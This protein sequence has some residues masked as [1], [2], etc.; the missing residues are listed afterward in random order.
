MSLATA[1][2]LVQTAN[3]I[4]ILSGAGL[5]TA[6]GIPDFRG[7]QGLWTADPEAEKISTLHYY[8][9]DDR[10]RR[11]AWQYRAGSPIWEAK[12]NA[13][14]LALVS[15]EKTGKLAGII[16]QNTD[17]LHQVA[18]NTPDLVHEIHGNLRQWRCEDCQITG[19]M[20]DAVRR[21]Q[22]GETDPR[23]PECGGIIRATTILFG[24]NLVPEVLDTAVSLAETCDLMLAI[25]T[26]L[27]VHPVAGL[28]PFAAYRGT[29][30]VIINGEDTPYDDLA[31]IVIQ[32]DILLTVP[33]ICS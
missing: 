26:S 15:L 28:V 21:V 4:V 22:A 8:L 23:C 2:N 30:I 32:D 20:I 11:L 19:P 5:S 17:G 24:E 13:A 31:E 10:V 27:T 9:H 1:R 29:P 18:G 16:T 12:P 7:P 6:S 33:T 14:H 25:G 3:R